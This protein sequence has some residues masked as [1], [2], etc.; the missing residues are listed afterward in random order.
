LRKGVSP[1]KDIL[2]KGGRNMSYL[3]ETN[4]VNCVSLIQGYIEK[5]PLLAGK[6]VAILALAQLKKIQAGD[7]LDPKPGDS[8]HCTAKPLAY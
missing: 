4:I 7:D 8:N 1:K 3:K 5:S 6:G 2:K